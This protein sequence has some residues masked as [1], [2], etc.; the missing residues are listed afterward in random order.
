M[1]H[2][3]TNAAILPHSSAWLL[4]ALATVFV[5][6]LLTVAY[7][8]RGMSMGVWVWVRGEW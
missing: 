4:I 3:A 2:L 7:R 5:L 1:S 8:L 6:A